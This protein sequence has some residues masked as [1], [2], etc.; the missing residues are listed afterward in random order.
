MPTMSVLELIA[1]LQ[2]IP[3]QHLPVHIEGCDCIG[4]ARSVDMSTDLLGRAI[5]MIE[6]EEI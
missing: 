6:R 2:K 1:E 3:D 5:V 4:G